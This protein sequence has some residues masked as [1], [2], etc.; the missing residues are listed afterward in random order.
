LS[1]KLESSLVNSAVLKNP[2]PGTYEDKY[3]TARNKDASWGF[4]SSTRNDEEKTMRRTC[5]FP[6]PNTYSP[7]YT[8]GVTKRPNW[9]FGSS[10]RSGLTVGKSD[11]PSMQTYNIPSKAVEGS[12][13]NMGLKL[14]SQSVLAPKKFNPPGAG[15]YNPDYT[16]GKN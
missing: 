7:D 9:G 14:D 13:W 2:G 11:A 4:G 1:K 12:N 10:K 6:P 8:V 15:T 5:N 16:V 3:K